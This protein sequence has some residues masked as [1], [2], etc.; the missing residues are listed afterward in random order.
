[1]NVRAVLLPVALLICAACLGACGAGGTESGAGRT[2]LCTTFPVYQIVRNVAVGRE[3]VDVQLMLPSQ[4]GCPHDYALTPQDM[5]R[6]A[7]ADVLVINGLGLE[8]FLGAP[9]QRANAA[10]HIIDSSSGIEGL[11]EYVGGHGHDEQFHGKE[12]RNAGNNDGEHNDGEHNDGEH[13]DGG[14]AVRRVGVHDHGNV[15]PHLFV[16]P[17]K[18][19]ELAMNIAAGL[20]E[21][22][23]EGKDIYAENGVLYGERMGDLSDAFATLGKRLANN[24]IVQPHGVYDYLA[25][26]AGLEIVAVMQPHGQEPS[27]AD[28]MDILRIIR[29]RGAGAIFI[30]PQYSDKVGRTL[31]KEAGIPLAVLD[32]VASGPEDAALNHYET[33]MRRNMRILESTLGVK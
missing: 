18:A 22:D 11:L 17:R 24:R 5:R 4:L 7:A 2:I 19:G 20:G 15:N 33:A 3:G 1:M 30:E 29:E 9:L 21:W 8:E 31:A 32:P 12:A 25:R 28:M 13:D 10:L 27:A 23:P 6:L 26:E 16:S 14:D